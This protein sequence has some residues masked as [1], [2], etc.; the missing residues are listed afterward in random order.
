MAALPPIML[1]DIRYVSLR[2]IVRDLLIET[3]IST[4]GEAPKRTD[5]DAEGQ[6]VIARRKQ[7]RERREA[8][9]ERQKQVQRE[10]RKAK[11]ALEYSK[12]MMREGEQEVQRAMKVGKGGLLGYMEV[13]TP[14]ATGSVGEK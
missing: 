7:D 1:A 4:L 12:G 9:A 10:K 5:L 3:H 8:L 14:H 2:P 11:E 13:D 6:E